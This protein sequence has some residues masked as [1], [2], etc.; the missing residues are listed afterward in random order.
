MDFVTDNCVIPSTKGTFEGLRS[1]HFDG[2]TAYDHPFR[3]SH[4]VLT[5]HW[6]YLPTIE[7][8]ILPLDN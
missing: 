2:P 4:N 3:H 7:F 5:P 8:W 1:A 6:T